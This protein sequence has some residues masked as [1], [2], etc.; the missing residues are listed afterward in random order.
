M[1]RGEVAFD[2]RQAMAV[3]C[4]GRIDSC[5]VAV[6]AITV[7]ASAI[8][9]IMLLSSIAFLPARSGRYF[10]TATG[11]P[12]LN[13]IC[14]GWEEPPSPPP[15][16]G[17]MGALISSPPSRLLQGSPTRAKSPRPPLRARH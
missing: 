14:S 2:Y 15:C 3:Y 9:P 16:S 4:H 8:E 7:V 17:L 6:T 11:V 5:A 12:S 10:G 13:L 1:R